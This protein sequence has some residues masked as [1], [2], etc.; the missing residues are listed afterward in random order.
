MSLSTVLKNNLFFILTFI[1]LVFN[2]K[3][4]SNTL[5]HYRFDYHLRL[6]F[7]NTK[8]NFYKCDSY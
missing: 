6:N 5:F 3:N 7:N 8:N 2:I 1:R 4:S